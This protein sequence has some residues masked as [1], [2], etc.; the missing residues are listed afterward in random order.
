[1]DEKQIL[2]LL[3]VTAVGIIGYFIKSLIGELK[4][5]EAKVNAN[6]VKIEVLSN[7]HNDLGRNLDRIFTA[8]DDMRND[9]KF[10]NK[11]Q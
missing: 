11:K 5:M 8:L 3:V 9:I 10:L 1:M 6:T 2:G 4:D 7:S